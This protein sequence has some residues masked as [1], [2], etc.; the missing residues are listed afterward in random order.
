M[1]RAGGTV[2]T[3]RSQQQNVDVKVPRPSRCTTFDSFGESAPAP[4][5]FEV[6]G[7]T[8]DEED[9]V[10]LARGCDRHNVGVCPQGLGKALVIGEDQ[11]IA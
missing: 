11:Y 8:K 9:T 6:K 3:P 2:L 7:I 10:F 4:Q 5:V 1:T